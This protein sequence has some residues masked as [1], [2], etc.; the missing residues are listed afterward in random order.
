MRI[1]KIY[2]GT[3]L[4]IMLLLSALPGSSVSALSIYGGNTRSSAKGVK[5]L[6][7]APSAAPTL[8]SSGQSNWVSTCNCGGWVQTGWRYYAGY[9]GATKYVE[10]NIAGTYG[11]TEYG[12]QGWG[13]TV[14]YKVT[15]S[16]TTWTAFIGGTSKGGWG[17]LN[18]GTLQV[19]ALSESHASNTELKTWFTNSSYLDSTFTWQY[20]DQA[21]WIEQ[22]PYH[23]TKTSLSQ[24][25][26]WG[27]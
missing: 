22:A 18:S 4:L 21:N 12:V 14:E 2:L 11:I 17:P 25:Q 10:H 24:Y 9:A 15:S 8:G 7:G 13:T 5:S 1:A 26:V 19:Q 16:N 20:F 3:F 23:V 27:P 6:I